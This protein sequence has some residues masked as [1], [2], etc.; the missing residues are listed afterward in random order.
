MTLGLSLL[1]G[2]IL[3]MVIHEFGHLL[4]ARLCSVQSSEFG[5][6]IGRRIFSVQLGSMIVSLRRWPLGSFVMLDAETLRQRSILRQL[7]V[8]LGGILMNLLAGGLFFG[9][10][11]GWLN[12]LLAVGNLLPVYQHD[13]WKCGMVLVRKLFQRESQPAE[14]AFTFSGGFVSLVVAWLVIRLFV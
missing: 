10:N 9:T 14:W 7:F 13:G 6:G 3:A 11:L 5:F 4:A 1:S 12:L 2:T 8:H